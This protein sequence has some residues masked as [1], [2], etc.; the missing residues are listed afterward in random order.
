SQFA[1]FVDL[2]HV[3]SQVIAQLCSQVGF[4][5]IAESALDL[6]IDV[7]EQY[8]RN[9]GLSITKVAHL[10]DD[11]AQLEDGLC[12]LQLLGQSPKA[13]LRFTQEVGPWLT[14]PPPT[15]CGPLFGKVQLNIP[16][17]GHEELDSRPKY[18][19]PHL[20][21][22][23]CLSET[24]GPH[25]SDSVIPHL[26][27]ERAQ[28]QNESSVIKSSATTSQ[29]LSDS[30]VTHSSFNSGRNLPMW[31][32]QITYRLTRISIDPLTK[33]LVEHAYERI[34]ESFYDLPDDTIT[35]PSKSNTLPVVR[36]EY[37][38]LSSPVNPSVDQTSRIC[39][40]GATDAQWAAA[41]QATPVP[42]P[43]KRI[44]F[45]PSRFDPSSLPAYM[46]SVRRSV[47]TGMSS[48]V[49][50]TP[51]RPIT[52][53][54]VNSCIRST[55]VA[56]AS[57]AKITSVSSKSKRRG[58]SSVGRARRWAH[59]RVV[60]KSRRND[61]SSPSL[62]LSICSTKVDLL[63]PS[64]DQ[65]PPLRT[66]EPPFDVDSSCLQNPK[67]CAPPSP[68]C[69]TTPRVEPLP[70]DS[71]AHKSETVYH[72]PEPVG[73]NAFALIQQCPEK[74]AIDLSPEK[75]LSEPTTSALD[76]GNLVVL[77][78][79]SQSAPKSITKSFSIPANSVNDSSTAVASLQTRARGH[80]GRKRGRGR[81]E[82]H[83]RVSIINSL[84]QNPL[85]QKAPQPRL[86]SASRMCDS[87]PFP[88][89][90]PTIPA[91][92][93]KQPT[94]DSVPPTV[95]TAVTK[96]DT[97][98]HAN[99]G[100]NPHYSKRRDRVS[101]NITKHRSSP[102][103]LD[104]SASDV[105]FDG[106][107]NSKSS[108]ASDSTEP[109]IEAIRG[110]LLEIPQAFPLDF[111]SDDNIKLVNSEL[112]LVTF[113][114]QS[115]GTLRS[116]GLKPT[117]SLPSSPSSIES[118][119]S[120][121]ASSISNLDLNG[122][123]RIKR[124]ESFSIKSYSLLL[125]RLT[126]ASRMCDSQPFPSAI[127]TIPAPSSKQPTPDSVPPT[128]PTAVTKPDTVAHANRGRNPHYSKRRDRVSQN[129]T[130]HR[131]SP[132]ALDVSASDVNFDGDGNSKSSPA[133]DSTEPMIEAIRGK[134]LEI[135]QA[136][137][138]DFKSDDNI[139]LVNSELK[140][141]T[142][143]GQSFGTLRSAGLK[144]TDS[145][146]SSP[147]SI[148]SS[149]SS[150]A[151][152]ISNLDLNG[153]VRIKRPESFSIKSCTDERRQVT[154]VRIPCLPDVPSLIPTRSHLSP[155]CS[156]F[157]SST[158]SSVDTL[159][160]SIGAS[161]LRPLD[162]PHSPSSTCPPPL[163]PLSTQLFDT[164]QSRNLILHPLRPEHTGVLP[165]P[166]LVPVLDLGTKSTKSESSLSVVPKSCNVIESTDLN[167]QRSSSVGL[168]GSV[169]VREKLASSLS[170][171]SSSSTSSSLSSSGSTPAGSYCVDRMPIKI[172]QPNVARDSSV[173]RLGG[174]GTPG[175]VTRLHSS[176]DKSYDQPDRSE[177]IST[178]VGSNFKSVH[179]PPLKLTIYRDRLTTYR[180]SGSSHQADSNSSSSSS[181]SENLLSS[182]DEDDHNSLP[183]TRP[184]H[185]PPPPCLERLPDGAS[186]PINEN[187][188]NAPPLISCRSNE[189]KVGKLLLT[190]RSS[191]LRD[192]DRNADVTHNQLPPLVPL[193]STLSQPT[194][195]AD[196]RHSSPSPDLANV[197]DR[198]VT[199]QNSSV[200]LSKKRKRPRSKEKDGANKRRLAISGTLNPSIRIQPS[201]H[202]STEKVQQTL[203]P[204]VR[205]DS[206]F[207][208]DENDSKSDPLV[209]SG[210][211]EKP[212]L[213]PVNLDSCTRGP[214]VSVQRIPPKGCKPDTSLSSSPR[215]NLKAVGDSK[216]A[217]GRPRTKHT[218]DLATTNYSPVVKALPKPD[219]QRPSQSP[220]VRS[221]QHPRVK[222]IPASASTSSSSMPVRGLSGSQ[223]QTSQVVVASAGSSY[224]FNLYDKLQRVYC[225]RF[226]TCLGLSAEPE[227]PQWFCP[228]CAGTLLTTLP[229]TTTNLSH[230]LTSSFVQPSVLTPKTTT[231]TL[232]GKQ[233]DTMTSTRRIPTVARRVK[234]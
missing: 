123:V 95:P 86:T 122:A 150:S 83:P 113:S 224:Y 78:E 82:P 115:F 199:K 99:R 120:S 152:S 54:S 62:P 107:G 111:K 116:A 69:D 153:A 41:L 26:H 25:P 66:S 193:F 65:T 189:S 184:A 17:D 104:V 85:R 186:L 7:A 46:S 164:S 169:K 181:G 3:M 149:F 207:T 195:S 37:V 108:P 84:F 90:I 72:L 33:N 24:N 6:L 100:R 47:T 103:A 63:S 28:T 76:D 13:L 55:P 126:S 141:V 77:L 34:P 18:I 48:A 42:Q 64:A 109:M 166:P 31:A 61:R 213:I 16:P 234:R 102:Q 74:P 127:P 134:L 39:S 81:K 92:S 176:L 222:H 175:G 93:S 32:S 144:P 161:P 29:S 210:L 105:N 89:A 148:E 163:L 106:D 223:R 71:C 140:L 49:S 206:V 43:A 192:G 146:P 212:P 218:A 22:N 190:S 155:S 58:S 228:K 135:P 185:L 94:P 27:S 14:A 137:P 20:P 178:D 12:A 60:R 51:K 124:P 198:T 91:P 30:G 53:R 68:V 97:V 38:A 52:P 114:G 57:T 177:A 215:V 200:N 118:S 128:V 98:A 183:S 233:K 232:G 129:I 162:M 208:D 167:S 19:P 87:Q 226:S 5:R 171:S 8:I 172:T 156:S 125:Q 2:R 197:S 168:L 160:P 157:A 131:S 45:T 231:I 50:I 96:P 201:V 10:S 88:S 173:I 225:F 35:R 170:P 56:R 132:Q 9:L 79:N 11:T 194:I 158:L 130:K 229:T 211:L 110:K 143:S 204:R 121:S 151:S 44:V 219:A 227:V 23:F 138:L 40:Q 147:S 202:M 191:P 15:L 101:Q 59:R 188:S 36:D 221:K 216:R 21:L 205:V 217:K 145:L 112:K 209:A 70:A 133:S 187:V 119:F 139:K 159:K 154:T 180:G 117:D 80:R 1:M 214:A 67:S 73:N 230:P 182:G 75:P 220:I 136:F 174:V 4:E 165:P 179:P 196:S 142:F 203:Q